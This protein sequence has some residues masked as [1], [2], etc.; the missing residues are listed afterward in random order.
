MGLMS[1]QN[2]ETINYRN[3]DNKFK[4]LFLAVCLPSGLRPASLAPRPQSLASRPEAYEEINIMQSP[5][6]ITIIIGIVCIGWPLWVPWHKH[7]FPW[8]MTRH[9]YILKVHSRLAV[10][11]DFLP[12]STVVCFCNQGQ[13]K[14]TQPSNAPLQCG[15]TWSINLHPPSPCKK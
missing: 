2:I 8:S 6:I 13:I 14:R 15:K 10:V 5:D 4:K 3:S 11:L 12:E 9:V 7:L 1:G